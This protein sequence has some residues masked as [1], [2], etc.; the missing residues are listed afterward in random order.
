M[1][2]FFFH[3]VLLHVLISVISLNLSAAAL[4]LK[5]VYPFTMDVISLIHEKLLFVDQNL[6]KTCVQDVPV[7]HVEFFDLWEY[8]N[9]NSS[10]RGVIRTSSGTY[11]IEVF[12]D[13]FFE[14]MSFICSSS[15]MISAPNTIDF[16]QQ[17]S[18]FFPNSASH[19]S[20]SFFE[21]RLFE[22][23]FRP[24]T[25]PPL[26]LVPLSE[27]LDRLHMF[28]ETHSSVM[29]ALVHSRVRCGGRLS[30]DEGSVAVQ[31]GLHMVFKVRSG[32]TDV[33]YLRNGV[34]DDDEWFAGGEGAGSAVKVIC[35]F[36]MQGNNLIVLS[37]H[38]ALF[39][40]EVVDL[41]LP[42]V[43]EQNELLEYFTVEQGS[44]HN[45]FANHYL[46]K[47]VQ[48][49]SSSV[50]F[51]H[52]SAFSFLNTPTILPKQRTSN[53]ESNHLT[54]ALWKH[55]SPAF[56]RLLP[57]D[58]NPPRPSDLN[59]QPCTSPPVSHSAP[60][61]VS[62]LQR[63]LRLSL[64]HSKSNFVKAILMKM[65][66]F[67]TITNPFARDDEVHDEVHPAVPMPVTAASFPPSRILLSKMHNDFPP[68]S[69]LLSAA[70][71]NLKSYLP[72]HFLVNISKRERSHS[73]RGLPRFEVVPPAEWEQAK[74]IPSQYDPLSQIVY[75]LMPSSNTL[76]QQ[77]FSLGDFAGVTVFNGPPRGLWGD[78]IRVMPA[79]TLV[80]IP[81]TSS[82]HAAQRKESGETSCIAGVFPVS[83][84]EGDEIWLADRKDRNRRPLSV[85]EE[86][87]PQET[88]ETLHQ[89]FC[90]HQGDDEDS[91]EEDEDGSEEE[92][93]E[94]AKKEETSDVD[95]WLDSLFGVEDEEERKPRKVA[96][97]SPSTRR[98]SSSSLRRIEKGKKIFK[99]AGGDSW[100]GLNECISLFPSGWFLQILHS[101]YEEIVDLEKSKRGLDS[102]ALTDVVH[103]IRIASD[104][105]SWISLD[106]VWGALWRSAP[107]DVDF[108]K[109]ETSGKFSLNDFFVFLGKNGWVRDRSQD[110][111]RSGVNLSHALLAD[112]RAEQ[113]DHVHFDP[114]EKFEDFPTLVKKLKDAI[115]SDYYL[116][117]KHDSGW[118]N[119]FHGRV[120]FNPHPPNGAWRGRHPS[121]GEQMIEPVNFVCKANLRQAEDETVKQAEIRLGNMIDFIF[122]WNWLPFLKRTRVF[123]AEAMDAKSP[124]LTAWRDLLA[125]QPPSV[126]VHHPSAVAAWVHRIPLSLYMRMKKGTETDFCETAEISMQFA[127]ST[128]MVSA[129]GARGLEIMSSD[130]FCSASSSLTMN[131]E[132]VSIV[133]PLSFLSVS[134]EGED[135]DAMKKKFNLVLWSSVKNGYSSGVM[136]VDR[137]SQAAFENPVRKCFMN[138]NTV[139]GTEDFCYFSHQNSKF[140]TIDDHVLKFAGLNTAAQS[141]LTENNLVGGN[142]SASDT[143]DSLCPVTVLGCSELSGHL[144]RRKIRNGEGRVCNLLSRESLKTFFKSMSQFHLGVAML[145]CTVSLIEDP[146][147]ICPFF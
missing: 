103:P 55:F 45:P 136:K 100:Y 65:K 28:Y 25:T 105:H 77:L 126:A 125:L 135:S 31:R 132:Q 6:V 58:Q 102:D 34:L 81:P 99:P 130:D 22:L 91:D 108:E 78:L 106:V 121:E 88:W 97:S 70:F 4:D 73:V 114:E 101:V 42:I 51:S 118:R 139:Q 104:G 46:P 16:L 143:K 60:S 109:E 92:D 146:R 47:T 116:S 133:T 137:I 23:H 145:K 7:A 56:S 107:L 15:S 134:L 9:D 90:A 138:R 13:S 122:E 82:S 48:S 120:L 10:P 140:R 5:I 86:E 69:A 50:S 79:K 44:N 67:D 3:H 64:A 61:A 74:V 72:S 96:S 71:F 49:Q 33:N 83:P 127:T 93:E 53:W 11:T 142:G 131:G 59:V 63:S 66:S 43:L 52:Q 38:D 129:S 113:R 19:D 12:Y 30:A 39:E 2:H 84:F 37:D 21:P 14:R 1:I 87:T 35:F 123:P 24:F 117:L 41:E 57:P 27:F 85:S 8:P 144:W 80:C 75:T 40:E 95:L 36:R 119:S 32:V 17:S 115:M 18:Y 62:I 20:S 112:I 111:M 89:K 128:S 76:R 147:H 68:M 141:F 110:L 94:S 29:P 98:S 124:M 54:G 26:S